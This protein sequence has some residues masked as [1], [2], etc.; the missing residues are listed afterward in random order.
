[1]STRKVLTVTLEFDMGDRKIYGPRVKA[2]YE[3]AVSAAIKAAK[4]E[5]LDGSV[6]TV[7]SRM[8]WDYRWAEATAL[9][10]DAKFE[11][12]FEFEDEDASRQ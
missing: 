7:S 8:T 10:T 2:A 3:S 9:D 6:S 12:D 11:D 5:L 4:A 1:M